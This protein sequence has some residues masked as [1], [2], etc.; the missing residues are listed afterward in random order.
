[1]KTFLKR[2]IALTLAVLLFVAPSTAIAA[3]TPELIYSDGSMKWFVYEPSP[4]QIK[5]ATHLKDTTTS[6]GTFY[7]PAGKNL[8]IT[9]IFADES[10]YR[11]MIYP[12]VGSA[13]IGNIE[14]GP[15]VSID[16]PAYNV[17]INYKVMISA[18]SLLSVTDYLFILS[19]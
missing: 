7:V 11:V 12:S 3:S 5:N 2:F 17:G 16:I 18:I 8:K 10:A 1:M 15:S 4:L 14:E 13:I 19:D 6:D 9:I